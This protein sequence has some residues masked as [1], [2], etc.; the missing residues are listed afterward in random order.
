MKFLSSA[1]SSCC[2]SAMDS[3][4]NAARLDG[5]RRY[6]CCVEEKRGEKWLGEN[7]IGGEMCASIIEEANK[8]AT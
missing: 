6:I 1:S 7:A 5:L 2:L 3:S 4:F 8:V